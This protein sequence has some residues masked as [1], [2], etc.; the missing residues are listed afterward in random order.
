MSDFQNFTHKEIADL[1]NQYGP[2]LKL[3]A[4]AASLD[5]ALILWALAGN[6][7]SF[8]ANCKPRFEP[9]YFTGKYSLSL[10]M[11][12]LIGQWGEDAAKSYGPWQ[13]MLVNAPG[14]TPPELAMDAE[15]AI[16]ATVGFLNR[17]VFAQVG[18]HHAAYDL[19]QIGKGWNRGNWWDGYQGAD[20]IAYVERLEHHYNTPMLFDVPQSDH[21]IFLN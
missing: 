17:R 6:E 2:L 12:E 8:G 15:R 10:S 9:A 7:S 11:R 19:A 5:P 1:C 14:F 4:Q 16:T 13:V 20:E 18:V 21:G 3:P